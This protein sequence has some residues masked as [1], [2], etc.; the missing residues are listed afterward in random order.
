MA[1]NNGDK[2]S[3]VK[4]FAIGA[5]ISAAAGYIAGILTAPQSGKET[6]ADIKNKA[7]E[8]YAAAERELKRLHTELS[9]TIDKVN[10]RLKDLQGRSAR[11]ADEALQKGRAVKQ[12]A[13]EVISALHDGEADD[14]ELRRAIKDAT[15]AIE[16]LRN[17][18]KK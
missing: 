18:L 3:A 6:R 10:S 5:L 9:E 15:D 12:K 16:H 2:N 1:H 8:S 14:K 7:T 11:E 4:I 13:R 17:Y